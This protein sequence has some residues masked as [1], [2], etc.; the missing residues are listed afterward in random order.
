[1]RG[2]GGIT[3]SFVLGGGVQF[4]MTAQQEVLESL[5]AAGVLPPALIAHVE[6]LMLEGANAHGGYS[7]PSAKTSS[8]GTLG[9]E[10]AEAEREAQERRE[11]LLAAGSSSSITK[12][13]AVRAA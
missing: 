10:R 6:E 11:Q 8:A 7:S 3:K 1:M 9:I 5:K 4:T 2:A 13:I 12:M